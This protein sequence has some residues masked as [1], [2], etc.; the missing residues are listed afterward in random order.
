MCVVQVRMCVRLRMVTALSCASMPAAGAY[1]ASVHT[2]RSSMAH[3]AKVSDIYIYT[4]SC[5]LPIVLLS[6]YVTPIYCYIH[7]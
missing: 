1:H 3:D 7:L 6:S 2:A 4:Y 5:G